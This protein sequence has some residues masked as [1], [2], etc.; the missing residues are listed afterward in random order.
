MSNEVIEAKTHAVGTVSTSRLAD[1]AKQAKEAA[2]KERPSVS[3]ISLKAGIISY[4]GQPVKDNRLDAIVLASTYRN[5]F[6]AG[7]Y[8]PNNIV[9][10]T[11]FALGESDEGLAPDAVVSNPV[12]ATCDGC[13]NREWGSDP[14]GGRGK[15]C[16][17]SRRLVLLPAS[18]LADPDPVAA[19]TRGELAVIDLPV[20]SVKNYSQYVNVLAASIGLPIWACVTEISTRPD[21]K[22]QFRVEFKGISGV[23]SDALLDAL[24]AK[25][26]EALRIGLIGYDATHDPDEEPPTPAASTKKTAKK[27]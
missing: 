22:S 4:G 11:C 9:N 18:V 8:D 12:H 23:D 20:M 14:G 17:E 13:P 3:K 25:K 6:Y 26:V 16:K 1:L 2:Q 27:F 15:A 19:I 10:P 5:N 7:K 21:P 24:E